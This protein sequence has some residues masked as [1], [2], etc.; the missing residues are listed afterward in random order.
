MENM[1]LT[2][3]ILWRNGPSGVFFKV[4]WNS[5]RVSNF[6]VWDSKSFCML[7]LWSRPLKFRI[8]MLVLMSSIQVNMD[9]I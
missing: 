4:R 3:K 7:L 2:A 9:S 6:G 5:W 1:M 8:K